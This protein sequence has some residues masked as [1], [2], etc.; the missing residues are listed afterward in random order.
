MRT[1]EGRRDAV[2]ATALTGAVALTVS[3]YDLVAASPVPAVRY[4]VAAVGLLIGIATVRS[5]SRGG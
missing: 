3:V 4:A 1:A 5:A 2:A